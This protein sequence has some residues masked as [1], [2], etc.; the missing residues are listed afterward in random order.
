MRTSLLVPAAL[1][2]LSHALAAAEPP[3]GNALG[4]LDAYLAL[5]SRDVPAYRADIRPDGGPKEPSAGRI[6][7]TGPILGP[8]TYRP[9]TYAE[10]TPLERAVLL[11][12]PG[13]RDFLRSH[14]V[15]RVE[16]SAEDILGAQP[17]RIDLSKP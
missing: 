6:R 1:V 2:F 7:G 8:F 17:V 4:L 9:K 3:K 16:V 10:L 11:R 5:A 14:A 12:E 13:L 15:R